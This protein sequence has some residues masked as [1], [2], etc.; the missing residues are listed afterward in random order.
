VAHDQYDHLGEEHR[1]YIGRGLAENMREW[2]RLDW[3]IATG[4]LSPL[5]GWR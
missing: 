1:N 2:S 4:K 5:E 3:G